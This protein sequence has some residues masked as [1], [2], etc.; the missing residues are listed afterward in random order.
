MGVCDC[1]DR[2]KKK[3]RN[4]DL[5]LQEEDMKQNKQNIEKVQK[6]K[7]KRLQVSQLFGY[8]ALWLWASYV[9]SQNP[10]ILIQTF[11]QEQNSWIR[12]N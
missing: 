9:P 1:F 10:H 11:L 2:E 8:S 3:A 7:I 4:A 6:N 12:E 5:R